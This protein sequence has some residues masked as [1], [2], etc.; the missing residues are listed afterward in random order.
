MITSRIGRKPLIIPSGVEVNIQDQKLFVKGSKGQLSVSLH[1]FV[2]V[3]VKDGHIHLQN[4]PHCGNI[5]GSDKKLNR[6]IVGT[7]R[8]TIQNIIHGVTHG[9]ERRL[10]LVGVGYRAQA[11]GKVLSLSLGFSHPTDFTV[12]EDITIEVPSQT[13]IVIKGI[14]KQVVGQTAAKIRRIRPPE[15]YKGKGVR[16]ANEIIELKE[17]KKK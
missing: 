4:N 7:L 8:A 10:I 5:T 13:E 2:Q 15:P 16:D 11:K 9:F 1:S 12:P 17:T 3:S 6:S 14:N